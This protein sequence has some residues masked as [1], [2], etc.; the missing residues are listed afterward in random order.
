MNVSLVERV[1]ASLSRLAP[2]EGSV[3][4]A[5]SGG[6]DSVALLDLLVSGRELHRRE[7]IVGHVDH[8]IH[9][10]SRVVAGQVAALAERL[11]VQSTIRHLTLGPDTSETLARK[12]RRRGLREIAQERGCSAI[13]L[14]HH[15]DDQ[16]ETVLQR[17]LRGSGPAGLAGMAARRGIWL[18]PLLDIP[19]TALLSH[20]EA[21]GLSAWHDP[22]N[23]DPRHLRSWLRTVVL[24]LLLE[25]D[26]SIRDSLLALAGQAAA[27]RRAWNQVPELLES[28]DLRV[29]GG[30][31]SVAAKA[32]RGYRSEVQGAV[33][34]A[35][36]RRFGVPLGA[37]RIGAVT[38]LLT[39][40]RSGAR[41][42][43]AP[44]LEAELA[45]DRLLLRR[46]AASFDP[47]PLEAD[48]SLA[49]GAHRLHVRTVRASEVPLD[50]VVNRT[51][52]ATGNYLV[53]PW[54][55]GDRIRPLGGRGS[56]TVAETFKESRVARGDRASWPV[57]VDADDQATV[58]WVPGICR[59]GARIPPAG[60]EALDV[61]FT[62]A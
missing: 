13:A 4:V 17:V 1:A 54:R 7:L 55:P 5:V 53:R 32:L 26:E 52:L 51:L 34:R 28:L 6:P 15:A 30:A 12:H 9:P 8:G 31:I 23:S 44:T 2:S 36:G 24:P 59:S 33:L 62:L 42:V 38:R 56:R 25:R 21:T 43:L 29:D 10:D 50:R 39:G 49:V 14:A 3:L 61:E 27:D 45:F 11:G 47:V 16:V 57:I 35:L 60:A 22:A 37:V 18:R 40:A 19:R 48:S 20:L 58:V 46:P 41:L